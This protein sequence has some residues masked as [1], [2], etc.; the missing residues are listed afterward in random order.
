MNPALR[1]GQA[2]TTGGDGT[3]VGFIVGAAVGAI[4]VMILAAVFG[5][6][7]SGA[8]L[9]WLASVLL[10]KYDKLDPIGW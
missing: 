4:V 10:Q 3:S 6:L 5:K 1:A 7:V 9:L 8:L 2:P